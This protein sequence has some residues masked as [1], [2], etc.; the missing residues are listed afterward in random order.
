[1]NATIIPFPSEIAKYSSAYIAEVV[2][3]RQEALPHESWREAEL[4]VR[5]ALAQIEAGKLKPTDEPPGGPS[6]A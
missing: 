3:S 4:A 2:Q 6:A 5:R 1:M